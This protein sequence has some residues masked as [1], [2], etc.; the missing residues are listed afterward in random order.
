MCCGSDQETEDDI[1]AGTETSASIFE[2]V[3]REERERPTIPGVIGRRRRIRRLYCRT[4]YDLAIYPNGKIRGTKSPRNKYGKFIDHY[5][6]LLSN[7]G[8]FI[9]I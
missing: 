4:G 5:I 9:L 3:L 8:M 6:V 2:N 7:A 1:P